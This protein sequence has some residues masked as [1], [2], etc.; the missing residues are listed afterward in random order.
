MYCRSSKVGH[1][2]IMEP[3]R[4]GGYRQPEIKALIVFRDL[5]IQIHGLGC[6]DLKGVYKQLDR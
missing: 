4:H 2:V 3:M 5:A 1:H 6:G